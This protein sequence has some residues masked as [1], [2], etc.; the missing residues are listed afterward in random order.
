MISRQKAAAVNQP[1]GCWFRDV[2]SEGRAVQSVRRTER[3]RDWLSWEK[4][5]V[6]HSQA[7]GWEVSLKVK[8]NLHQRPNERSYC[9][10]PW[11]LGF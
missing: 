7:P 1:L 6:S 2:T 8:W 10:A 4:Q 9:E 5:T 11:Q 3:D